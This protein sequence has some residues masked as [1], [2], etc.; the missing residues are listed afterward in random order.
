[1]TYAAVDWGGLVLHNVVAEAVDR[2]VRLRGLLRRLVP[3]QPRDVHACS[4]EL[5]GG[6]QGREEDKGGGGGEGGDR[7]EGTGKRGGGSG[8]KGGGGEVGLG[9]RGPGREV[10]GGARRGAGGGAHGH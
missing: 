1:M 4:L 7:R 10:V 2:L 8:E 9:A 3:W 6:R 5:A